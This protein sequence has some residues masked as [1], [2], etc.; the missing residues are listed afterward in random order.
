MINEYLLKE[1]TKQFAIDVIKL[2]DR[3]PIN[4]IAQVIGKQLLRSATSI[5]ANYRS[6]CRAKSRADF[7]SK[8]GIVEE[9]AEE[10]DETLY[11]LE[12]LSEVKLVTENQVKYLYTE[13]NEIIAIVVASIKTARLNNIK[14]SKI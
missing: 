12:L 1:R 9:E 4:M 11:W 13:A 8:M 3:L 2:I 5:G 14:N 10:A 7:I 6:S